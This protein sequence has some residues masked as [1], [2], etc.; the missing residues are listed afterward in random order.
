MKHTIAKSFFFISTLEEK[1][2]F[3]EILQFF[4]FVQKFEKLL[5]NGQFELHISVGNTTTD[6]STRCKAFGLPGL[7]KRHQTTIKCDKAM[8]GDRF[9]VKKMDTGSL[10][11]FE[12]Y[13][14]SKLPLSYDPISFMTYQ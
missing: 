5:I 12:V 7:I 2:Y 11:L 13:L 8:S 3:S 6:L 9:I 4:Y 10:R 14:I 1:S